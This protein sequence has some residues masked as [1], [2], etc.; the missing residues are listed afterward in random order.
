MSGDR[1]WVS[2]NIAVGEKKL[3]DTGSIEAVS[4]DIAVFALGWESRSVALD[5]HLRLDV[6]HLLVL[7]FALAGTGDEAIEA[8]R[9]K[10]KKIA[11]EWGVGI[12]EIKLATS[13]D[14]LK[15]IN[16][17]EI[18]IAEFARKFGTYYGSLRRVFVECSTM[19]RVYIQ[20][21][22]AY[23][24][25]GAGC[26]PAL[27]FGYA[28]G[29]Y[30]APSGPAEF[31]SVVDRYETVPLLNGSGGMGEEKFLIVG[32]GGDADMFYGLVHE[33]SP[34]RVAVLVPHSERHEHLDSLLNQQVAKVTEMYRLQEE[35]VRRVNSFA[36]HGYLAAF[37]DYATKAGDRAV[38]SVFAG[39]PK[40][41][42]IASAIFA[43][44]DRRVQVKARIP[45][46]YA[47]RD[48]R[49]NGSYH[50]FRL[51]D[52]TSPACSLLDTW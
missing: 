1:Y 7:D 40:V 12:S 48:V 22:I 28:E 8:N 31:S 23:G 18:A 27:D 6:K 5:R 44:A 49:S 2:G 51:V 17:L 4:A 35:E 14:F 9:R 52:L 24:F 19:P 15:N 25:G 21:L 34:E 41:Q 37:E 50:W 16:T 36:I 33:F 13:T 38:I 43:C 26:F 29:A 30:E 10:L 47:R 39:G 32:I 46:S 42:A 11:S 3:S 45:K 20:W